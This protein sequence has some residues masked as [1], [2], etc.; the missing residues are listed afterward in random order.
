MAWLLR[1]GE[2][3]ASLEV[4]SSVVARS[5]GLLGKKTYEGAILLR[6][7]R[8]VHT[9]GMRFAIDVAFL[10]DDLAVV[11]VDTLK[12]YRIALPRRGGRSVLEA[13]RAPSSGGASSRATAWRSRGDG[14]RPGPHRPGRKGAGAGGSPPAR[15]RAARARRARRRRHPDR[16]RRRPLPSRRG[17][18]RRGRRLVLR[19]HAP[20]RDSCWPVS[21]CVMPACSPC[22]RHNESQRVPEVLDLL[23]RG[24]KVAL[25]SD[26]GTPA[27]SDPG[28][29]LITA[30]IEAGHKVTTRPGAFGGPERPRGGGAWD[31]D[32]G[33]SRASCRDGGPER[34]AR[35][36][37][38]AGA[39]HPSVV[40]EAPQRVASTLADLAAAC[41]AGRK[42][43]VC[44]E[45]TK[46]F[47]ETWRGDLWPR[48][49]PAASR[50]PR[51]ASTS[52]SWPGRPCRAGPAERGGA[53]GRGRVPGCPP[54]PAGAR[55][56]SRWRPSWA[57]R[58]GSP[59]R[60]RSPTATGNL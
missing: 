23:A 34:A 7:T 35:L 58:S 27:I 36:A 42:V 20:Y 50:S 16:Q 12:P 59:T 30:A 17:K 11:A 39:P 18:H 2:V 47:E 5:R 53:A 45:L 19:G 29:L 33:V 57:C 55:P 52:S 14:R 1:D 9:I 32:A 25:V 22:T 8:S 60:L 31:R 44:R 46:R 4:A 21:A 6:R 37:E 48:R 49:A 15:A 56:R 3:L 13:G 40:Y 26:A 10:A 41:G 54:A 38:I 24:A 51:A 43:A 28:E